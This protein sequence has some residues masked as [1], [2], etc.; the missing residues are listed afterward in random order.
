M[1]LSLLAEQGVFM[2]ELLTVEEGATR[3][4]ISVRTLREWLRTGKLMGVKKANTGVCG[5]RI[6][7]PL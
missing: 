1:P 2:N 5:N 3:L 6:S 4:K 7:Q